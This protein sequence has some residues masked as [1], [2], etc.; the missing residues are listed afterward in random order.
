M[1]DGCTSI[2]SASRKT[3]SSMRAKLAE[4]ARLVA[5]AQLRLAEAELEEAHA[6]EA[7]LNESSQASDP[8]K[9]DGAHPHHQCENHAHDRH[10]E[11][12]VHY[13]APGIQDVPFA[14]NS[15]HNPFSTSL[16]Q[17]SAFIATLNSVENST[18]AGH[19]GQPQHFTTAV[20]STFGN[21]PFDEN[22][23]QNLLLGTLQNSSP[24]I[25]LSTH[26]LATHSGALIDNTGDDHNNHPHT[27][28]QLQN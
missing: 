19:F 8:P 28:Q 18:P 17:N 6:E 25:D 27:A 24:P 13:C 10:V 23:G 9:H 22:Q 20:S 4:K 14:V 12:F 26:G 2:A 7:L 11:H 16:P 1:A 21:R 15:E 5:E 3:T